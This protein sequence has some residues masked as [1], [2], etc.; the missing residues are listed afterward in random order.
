MNAQNPDPTSLPL[1]TAIV[2]CY[3]HARFVIEALESIR[4]QDYPRLQIVIIDDCSKD[5]CPSLVRDWVAANPALDVT[6]IQNE[7]NLG[8]CKTMNRALTLAK[9][10]YIALA[11]GDDVWEM[12][13]LKEKVLF[14]DSLPETVAVLY[15]DAHRVDE[16]GALLSKQFIS[17]WRVFDRMPE[18]NVNELLWNGNWI[19]V[20]T[21]IIRHSAFDKVGHYDEDLFLEDW[22]MWLRI[23][24]HFHFA[25]YPKITARYRVVSTSISNSSNDKMNL[26][27]ELM[28]TKNLLQGLVPRSVM[29]KAFN[30]AIRRIFRRRSVAY[31]EGLDILQ[32]LMRRYAS[33]R[34]RY[35]WALY[36]CG[37][38]YGCYEFPWSMAKK[39]KGLFR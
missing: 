36:R 11:S 12:E 30:Y 23:S 33:P 14:M 16:N 39:L 3:N 29:N 5:S 1:V 2:P 21:T 38:G 15:S 20:P 25:Y 19:P 22:D 13:T 17:H 35:A 24:R 32:Q 4:T 6:F 10:K 9:G 18:G 34:P 28:F 26:A 31:Q 27:N 7:K 8:V 37:I